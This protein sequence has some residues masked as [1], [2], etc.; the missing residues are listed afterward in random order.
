MDVHDESSL[1]VDPSWVWEH[2]EDPGVRIVDCGSTWCGTSDVYERVHLPGA[3]HLPVHGWL[4]RTEFGVHVMDPPDFAAVMSQLGISADT[5]VVI[6]DDYNATFATRLWWVLT[7]YGHRDA[8]VLDGGFRRWVA[9]GRRLSNRSTSPPQATFEARPDERMIARLEDVRT[10]VGDPETQIVNALWE[11]WFDGSTAP[12]GNGRRGHI[13][14]SINLPVERFLLSEDDPSFLP[15]DELAAVV[16]VAG[17][18]PEKET[19]VHCWGGV[20][21]TLVV[22]VL[23]RLG[24]RNVRAYDAS[25]AEWADRDDT[26]L[27]VG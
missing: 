20:R 11:D 13:P 18:D 5:T 19:I 1:I 26:P 15:V 10:R 12:F 23:V 4:K 14:G 8:G 16:E 17:L 21:T 22:F 24:W 2:R 9:E 7:Y 25:L 3:V 6:Y 27:V